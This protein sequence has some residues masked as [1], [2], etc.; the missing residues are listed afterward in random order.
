MYLKNLSLVHF[1]NYNQAELNFSPKI[2]CFVG[3]NGTGKT[4]LL[5]ALYYLA[6]TKSYFNPVDSQNIKSGEHFFV[7][8]GTFDRK[9]HEE[10]IYCGVKK[11]HKKT[12]KRNNKEY[13]KLAEHIGLFPEVIVTPYDSKLILEGS[14]ERRRFMDSVISQY[15][16]TYLEYLMKYNRALSHRNKLLKDFAASDTFSPELLETIDEQMAAWAAYIFEQRRRFVEPLI[17]IFQRYYNFIAQSDEQ[18]HLSYQ[19]ALAKKD[20]VSLL[21]E[22][23]KRDLRMQHTTTG[24]HRDDLEFKIMDFPLKKVAS[25]GQQKT[26]LIAIKLAQLDFMY[27]MHGLSA[28]LLLDDIFDK[29]DA[30]RT[31]KIL[32]LVAEDRFGQI[33]ITDTNRQRLEQMLQSVDTDYKVFEITGGTVYKEP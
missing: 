14:E 29:L 4:N 32:A 22:N 24:I 16:K 6:F 30:S 10:H 25:Q 17:P 3:D 11:G 26:Y 9:K 15:D 8:E 18:I 5:D 27:E 23:R 13:E 2:N 20:L 31:A 7:L 12:F 33:F 21:R 19:S 1:K 28:I